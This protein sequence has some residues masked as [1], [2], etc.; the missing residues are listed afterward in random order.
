[1]QECHRGK[2]EDPVVGSEQLDRES[3]PGKLYRNLQLVQTFAAEGRQRL[4]NYRHK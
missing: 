1:M 2:G 3:L 4:R